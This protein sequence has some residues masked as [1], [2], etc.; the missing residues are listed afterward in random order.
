M[1]VGEL[2]A[3]RDGELPVDIVAVGVTL[4]VGEADTVVEG[5]VDAETLAV[6]VDE[7]ELPLES[8]PVAVTLTLAVGE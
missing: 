4:M 8:V 5:D 3:D 1:P 2:D 6:V 7:G